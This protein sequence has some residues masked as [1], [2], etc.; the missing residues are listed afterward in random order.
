MLRY[1]HLSQNTQRLLDKYRSNIQLFD[2]S[3][4]FIETHFRK[5]AT[6]AYYKNMYHI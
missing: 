2:I 6:Q 3:G 5:M 4:S 1:V